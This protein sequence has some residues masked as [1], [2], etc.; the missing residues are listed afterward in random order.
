MLFDFDILIAWI[1]IKKTDRITADLFPCFLLNRDR[2]LS[3]ETYLSSTFFTLRR[4]LGR[5]T[6]E[7][8]EGLL[9]PR[10]LPASPK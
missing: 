7:V 4:R 2:E 9:S 5:S 6:V 1:T 8:L 10:P 3:H